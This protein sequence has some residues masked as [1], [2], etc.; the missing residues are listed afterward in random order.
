MGL[1]RRP[2]LA[3][4]ADPVIASSWGHRTVPLLPDAD[5]LQESAMGEYQTGICLDHYCAENDAAIRSDPDSWAPFT[6]MI[7]ALHQSASLRSLAFTQ[8]ASRSKVLM[9]GIRMRGGGVPGLRGSDF[10]PSA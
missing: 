7:A 6:A 4:G 1:K 2:R 8:P 5:L 3:R 9:D 10:E